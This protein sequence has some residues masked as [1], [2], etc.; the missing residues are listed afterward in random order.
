M[1]LNLSITFLFDSVFFL[2]KNSGVPES[3]LTGDRD[4]QRM[5]AMSEGRAAGYMEVPQEALTSNDKATKSHC[6]SFLLIRSF[7]ARSD[8]VARTHDASFFLYIYSLEDLTVDIEPDYGPPPAVLL[9]SSHQRHGAQLHASYSSTSTAAATVQQRQQQQQQQ[10]LQHEYDETPIDLLRRQQLTSNA[11]L[12]TPGV[13]QMKFSSTQIS[14]AASSAPARSGMLSSS[15]HSSA[16]SAAN[17]APTTMSAGGAHKSSNSARGSS[18]QSSAPPHRAANNHIHATTNSPQHSPATT[19][20]SSATATVSES[21]GSHYDV[22]PLTLLNRVASN[23]KPAPAAS[24]AAA[25]AATALPA[26]GGGVQQAPTAVSQRS[27]VVVTTVPVTQPPSNYAQIPP[28]ISPYSNITKKVSVH[29]VCLA[30]NSR[31]CP[32]PTLCAQDKAPRYDGA[33]LLVSQET[34]Y[35]SLAPDI[36]TTVS[37]PLFLA[38]M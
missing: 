17:S 6:K 13:S 5:A 16:M 34:N 22:V 24:A 15:S 29:V 23:P 35:Q 33:P 36:S 31:F 38:R 9:A 27:A 28:A 10:Q 32:S 4:L 18:Q 7:L 14:V 20:H 37:L 8:G 12:T 11:S 30:P 19:R 1:R 2:S 21:T 26:S 3:L 25:A